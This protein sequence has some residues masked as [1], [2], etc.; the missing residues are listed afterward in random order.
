M[1]YVSDERAYMVA[2]ETLTAFTAGNLYSRSSLPDIARRVRDILADE[3]LS[4]R[5]SLC[6]MIAKQ[7]RA[8]WFARVRNTRAQIERG[9]L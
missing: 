1:A 7:A 4:T 9:Q 2:R 3:G 5:W 8:M 6:L